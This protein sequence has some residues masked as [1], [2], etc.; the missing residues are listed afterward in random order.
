MKRLSLYLSVIGMLSF[1]SAVA[2]S[3]GIGTDTPDP[4]AIMELQSTTQ[5]FLAP[6]MTTTQ[7]NAIGVVNG[8]DD[9]LMIYNLSTDQFNY[10]DGT[11]WLAMP[12]LSTDDDWTRGTGVMYPSNINDNV[13]IGTSTPNDRLVVSGGRV[14]ITANTDASGT[15]GTGSLEIGNSL[16]LDGNEII[17][18]T[19]SELLLQFGNNGDL[20][21]DD[22]TLYVDASTNFVGIGT[23]TPTDKLTVVD[24]RVSITLNTD[25]NGTAGTGVLEIGNSLRLDGNEIIT[26]DN[27]ILYVN[28]DNNGDV[29]M[30]GNTFRLDASANRIGIGTGNPNA[31]L[32]IRAQANYDPILALPGGRTL[33]WDAND[34]SDRYGFNVSDDSPDALYFY[35]QEGG[36]EQAYVW[37]DGTNSANE[38]IFGVSSRVTGSTWYP[39]FII[40]QQGDIGIG[41]NFPAYD[42]TLA[43]NSAAKPGSTTWTVPS[44][45]KL[46][47]N[48]KP[49]K[50]GLDEILKVEPVW[51]TYNGKFGL[52]KETFVG[53]IAQDLEKVFPHMIQPIELMDE[54]GLTEEISSVDYHAMSFALINAVKELNEK[55]EKQADDLSKLSNM[56]KNCGCEKNEYFDADEIDEVKLFPNPASNSI[57]IS[58]A[59][60]FRSYSI[61]DMKGQVV[62]TGRF[63][64]QINIHNLSRG[65]YFL[66]LKG[67]NGEKLL[68]FTKQ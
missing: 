48:I 55:I 57:N 41:T 67:L 6:R 24:G 45:K 25:A 17:T 21:V 50:E 20:S 16:R 1:N 5:G 30:D 62:Q 42:L 12:D 64:N 34:D 51:Y 52:P 56:I 18:N 14:V 27:T 10:W 53:T 8:Q 65:P 46:K 49:Y 40:D 33:I 2:Q 43:N 23:T 54:S 32:D 22:N 36:N 26:N 38:V 3:F 63:S 29:L 9:G 44:D 13:G 59:E 28:S 60:D 66:V 7:R 4:Q 31:R 39:R 58:C 19:N 68:Q 15:V 11:Q 61:I 47:T 37:A 35:A